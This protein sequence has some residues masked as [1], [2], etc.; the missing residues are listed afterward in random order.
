MKK[1]TSGYKN[2]RNAAVKYIADELGSQRYLCV[3]FASEG[4]A[5]ILIEKFIAGSCELSCDIESMNFV[6][7]DIYSRLLFGSPEPMFL[8]YRLTDPDKKGSSYEHVFEDSVR[9]EL[10]IREIQKGET[11]FIKEYLKKFGNYEVIRN[12]S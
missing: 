4:R 5:G 8:E 7:C 12:I 10:Y 11:E 9:N 2:M 6:E 3:E 1:I